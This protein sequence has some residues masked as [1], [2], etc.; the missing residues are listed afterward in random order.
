LAGATDNSRCRVGTSLQ[1]TIFQRTVGCSETP[2]HSDPN[3]SASHQ[4]T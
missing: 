3:Y 1:P 2:T 4:L